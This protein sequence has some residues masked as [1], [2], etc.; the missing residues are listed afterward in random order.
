M[1]VL[2]YHDDVAPLDYI[3]FAPLTCF[4]R[5]DDGPACLIVD[6][7]SRPVIIPLSL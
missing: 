3:H 5:M 7:S 2:S 4:D 1:A 6:Y